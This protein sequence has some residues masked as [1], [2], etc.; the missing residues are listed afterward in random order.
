MLH[1]LIV[2]VGPNWTVA[3]SYP[4][5]PAA[6]TDAR[7]AST[8][9]T[10]L[11]SHSPYCMVLLLQEEHFN[12]T[13]CTYTSSVTRNHAREEWAI[14]ERQQLYPGQWLLLEVTNEAEGEP[15]AGHLIAVAAEAA[16]SLLA[17]AVAGALGLRIILLLPPGCGMFLSMREEA[18]VFWPSSSL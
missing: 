7:D 11:Q 16:Q 8:S 17:P 4:G 1:R 13:D 10:L 6:R 2:P 15:I 9:T 14:A 3:D 5:I 18:T 12:V